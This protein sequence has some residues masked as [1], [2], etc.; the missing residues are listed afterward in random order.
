MQTPVLGFHVA[1][2]PGA[3]VGELKGM[4]NLPGNSSN[5]LEMIIHVCDGRLEC[6]YQDGWELHVHA[7]TYAY[8]L[9][10]FVCFWQIS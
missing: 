6:Y 5:V 7:C 1:A 10:L 9:A 2:K 3:A 4:A 8:S